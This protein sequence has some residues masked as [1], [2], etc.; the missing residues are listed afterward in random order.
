MHLFIPENNQNGLLQNG[1]TA[2][3]PPWRQT[4]ASLSSREANR[5][6]AYPPNP[7][8]RYFFG[9]LFSYDREGSHAFLEL[10]AVVQCHAGSQFMNI[11][12]HHAGAGDQGRLG[13]AVIISAA[14]SHSR[15][16]M[17]IP[18]VKNRHPACQKIT[19][20]LDIQHGRGA[21]PPDA[22]AR[23]RNHGGSCQPTPRSSSDWTGSLPCSMAQAPLPPSPA[24]SS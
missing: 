14:V 16:I 2:L 15:R 1:S 8:P 6:R 12:L 4:A 9:E 13:Y 11:A 23:F 18:G 5:Y 17:R 7:P 10:H 20:T 21:G 22:Q 19:G 3:M 24:R